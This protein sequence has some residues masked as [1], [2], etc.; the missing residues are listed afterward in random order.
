MS[1][2]EDVL[3]AAARLVDAFARGD[4]EAYFGSFADDATFLFHSHPD[5]IAST[6]A[7]RSVWEGWVRD[8]DLRVLGATSSEPLVRFAG[9]TV[10]VF[11]HRVTTSLRTTDGDAVLHER[12]TIVFELRDGRWIAVHEHL[13]PDPILEQASDEGAS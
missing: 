4:Q 12:E 6:A 3:A 9:S 8:D 5:L 13:S 10:A 7:Y 2:E 1:A 11:L